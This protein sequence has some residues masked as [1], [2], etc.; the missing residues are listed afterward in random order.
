M[1]KEWSVAAALRA[2]YPSPPPKEHD[3]RGIGSIE[4][5]RAKLTAMRAKP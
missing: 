3:R 1:M 4:W 2:L 5:A